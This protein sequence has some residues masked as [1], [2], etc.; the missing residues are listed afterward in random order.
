MARLP[1]FSSAVRSGNILFLSGQIGTE[2]GV[3]PL[4]VVEGGPVAEA[5]QT[6]EHIVDLAVPLTVDIN[7]GQNLAEVKG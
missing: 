5:R 7:T 6:M 4:R 1:V 2:P 3:E